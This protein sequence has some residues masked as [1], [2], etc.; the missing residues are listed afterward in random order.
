MQDVEFVTDVDACVTG[1]DAMCLV[2][3]WDMFR[4][5]DMGR[6]RH[7]MAQPVVVDLRNVY[8]ADD[9]RAKGFHYVDVGRGHAPSQPVLKAVV[10]G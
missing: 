6:I 7:L 5:L 8:S 3:E 2:T 9:M 4:G 10:N 1:A